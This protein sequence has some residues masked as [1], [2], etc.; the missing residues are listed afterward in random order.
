MK[1]HLG[2]QNTNDDNTTA[3]LEILHWKKG[4]ILYEN[5]EIV[6]HSIARRLK[7]LIFTEIL[8][9]SRITDLTVVQNKDDLS[10][11][12]RFKSKK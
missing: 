2:I 11:Q 7:T 3:T 10:F 5:D 12:I 4:A 8:E 6:N 1:R 9:P